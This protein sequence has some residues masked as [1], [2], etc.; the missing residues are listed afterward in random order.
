MDTLE[1]KV[2]VVT[3]AT[4]GIGTALCRFLAR[5]RCRLGLLSRTPAKLEKLASELRGVAANLSAQQVDVRDRESVSS[6][7][8]GMER[9]LG[10]VDVLIHNAGDARLTD[11]RAP[12]LDDLDEMLRVNYLGGVY[13]VA[14]VL[15][16]ML[17]RGNGHVVAIS[18]LGARRALPWCAG[19]AASKVA[20]ATYLESL[21]PALRPRG[22][23]VTTVYSGFVRTAMSESLPFRI[24]ILMMKP[25]MAAEKIVRAIVKGRREAAFPWYEAACMG[26][27]RRLPASLYDG[28]IAIAGRWTIRGDY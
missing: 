17:A 2:V 9:E 3:G 19:Y 23:R 15:P 12:S 18:S 5:H 24:P 13:A 28:L 25:E 8:A 20:L 16:S 11:A 6:A 1:D 14:A 21:R 27:L 7:L 26:M 4:G 10:A 22:I